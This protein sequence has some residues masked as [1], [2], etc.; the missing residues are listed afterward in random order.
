ME[1]IN[2][3]SRIDMNDYGIQNSYLLDNDNDY[4]NNQLL[5]GNISNNSFN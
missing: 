3:I 4:V 2:Y 5:S 1:S